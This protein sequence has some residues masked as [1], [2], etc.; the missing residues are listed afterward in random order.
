M[1]DDELIT[2]LQEQRTKVP[3]TAPVDEIIGRGRAIGARRRIFRLAAALTTAAA[4][5]VAVAALA[6][7][8]HQPRAKLGRRGQ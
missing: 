7:S 5:T 4:V 3:M 8:R 2:L 1:N 6:S